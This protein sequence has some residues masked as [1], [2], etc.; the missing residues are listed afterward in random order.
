MEIRSGGR[1]IGVVDAWFDDAAV[2]VEFDGLVKYTSPWRDPGRVLWDEKRRE[3]EPRALDIRFLRI[4]AED[5][6]R[7]CARTEAR[8]R[9]LLARSGPA[10]RG[11]TAVPR[12]YGIRRRPA[13]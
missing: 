6:H 3:D 2:A 10:V 1:L 13:S 8:L 11:F 4:A 12:R 5:L 9:E 7:K